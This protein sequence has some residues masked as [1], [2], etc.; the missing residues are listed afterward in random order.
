MPPSHSEVVVLGAGL[1]GSCTALELAG[2]G[3]DVTII[4]RDE[5]AMNRASLRNEGKIHLGLVYANDSSMASGHLQLR[6]ALSFRRLIQRWLGDALAD[7]RISTPFTYLVASDSLRS[8]RELAT[9]YA[10]LEDIYRLELAADPELDYL[11]TNP[12][13]LVSDASW[14]KLRGYFNEERFQ[15]AFRT[16]EL[17]VDTSQLAR[18]FREALAE[19]P[20]I[21]LLPERTINEVQDT[22]GLLRLGGTGTGGTWEMTAEHV[23]NATWESRLAL[24]R[25]FGIDIAE[26]WLHRLKYRVIARLPE[27]MREAP[28]VTMVLGAYGDVVVRPSGTAYLSW[29]PAGLQG[30]THDIVPPEI[31]DAPCRGEVAEHFA[32]EIA[33]E[34]IDAIGSWYPSVREARPELVDAGVIVA[35]GKTDVDTLDSGLHDRTR[36]GVHSAGRF[37]SLDPGKLT[38]APLFAMVAADRVSESLG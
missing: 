3:L 12:E 14:G 2:R 18:A 20:R 35:Y 32:E 9:Y 15:G 10:R 17:A 36:V 29:Y 19:H 16:A 26:G 33:R 1:A 27:S 24:D 7:V 31:W 25:H 37:H 21:R 38:T 28:S 22:S 30:W 34:T 11:G 4:D 23:V 6:G 13:R 5:C 8:M